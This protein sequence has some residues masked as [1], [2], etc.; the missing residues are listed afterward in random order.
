MLIS[1]H[2]ILMMMAMKVCDIID[3][4]L[5]KNAED[6][7]HSADGLLS[8]LHCLSTKHALTNFEAGKVDMMSR[9]SVSQKLYGREREIEMLVGALNRAVQGA[10]EVSL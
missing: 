5:A 6:R 8:D 10:T 9:F 1:L 2:P 7:Y 3:K 4:L